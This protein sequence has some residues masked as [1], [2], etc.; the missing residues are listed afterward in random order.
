MLT[1]IKYL[2]EEHQMFA[3]QLSVDS[4]STETPYRLNRTT[5][6]SRAHNVT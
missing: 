4:F 1:S 6:A 5:Q 3:L 2:F